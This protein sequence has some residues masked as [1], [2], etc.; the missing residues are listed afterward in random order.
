MHRMILIW[1]IFFDLDPFLKKKNC[2]VTQN[3]KSDAELKNFESDHRCILS[4]PKEIL[5][6]KKKKTQIPE[7]RNAI[8]LW[9]WRI[10][11]SSEYDF[12]LWRRGWGLGWVATASNRTGCTSPIRIDTC[13]LHPHHAGDV[14]HVRKIQLL[15]IWELSVI[16]LPCTESGIYLLAL[17]RLLFNFSCFFCDWIHSRCQIR[18]SLIFSVILNSLEIVIC[19]IHWQE[20]KKILSPLT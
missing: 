4:Q 2:F 14:I 9:G 15:H 7:Q 12:R 6:Q 17:W 13:P 10:S 3:L 5:R 18:F 11:G 20:Q 19:A 1:R 8:I 16:G